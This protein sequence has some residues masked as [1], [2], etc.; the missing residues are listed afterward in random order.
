MTSTNRLYY[1]LTLFLLSIFIFFAKTIHASMP[2]P[3][4]TEQTME[5]RFTPELT[6]LAASLDHDPVKIFKWVYENIETPQ[7]IY[8]NDSGIA[9]REFYRN[10]RLGAHMTYLTGHGNNWDV[11][12]LL[13]TLLRLSGIPAR[14]ARYDDI[15]LPDYV[16][17]E[18]WIRQSNYRN[19][20]GDDASGK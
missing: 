7:T 20:S 12:S 19:G 10:S 8:K 9:N 17:V 16:W 15:N 18:A 14:Y 13:I 2:G 6:A 3:E 11:S 4:Y 5:C 1:T